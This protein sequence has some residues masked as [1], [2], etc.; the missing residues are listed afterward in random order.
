[1]SNVAEAA[2]AQERAFGVWSPAL[3]PLDENLA[4]D[5][6]RGAEHMKWLLQSG[7]HGIAL[8]GTT[9]EATSFSVEERMDYLD[10]ILAAGVPA[11]QLMVGTGCC[12]IT[13]SVRLSNHALKSGCEKVL[14]L[15]PFY[16]KGVSDDGV[17][18]SYAEVL[19]RVGSASLQLYFYHF[20][21]LSMVP[22]SHAVIE[23]VT[24]AYPH[25]VAGLKDLFRRRRG[26]CR[27]HQGFSGY[28]YFP[29]ERNID[30]SHVETRWRRL[31][32]GFGQREPSGH[33]AS[34]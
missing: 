31:H 18:A 20:P 19:E 14:M 27:L 21:K 26:L 34:L 32:Y 25:N 13:D 24:K 33:S 11:S 15:P 28:G 4:P 6:M 12:A 22:I 29:G 2:A 10:A 9:S 17:Y 8:F 1:M 5:A 3:T 30:A 7:C 16:Y 23:R